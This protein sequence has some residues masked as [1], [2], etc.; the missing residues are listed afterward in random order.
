MVSCFVQLWPTAKTEPEVTWH[1]GS[2]K[3][4]GLLES[5]GKHYMQHA[6]AGDTIDVRAALERCTHA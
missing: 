3:F 6:T 4:V 2:F 1:L 5:A